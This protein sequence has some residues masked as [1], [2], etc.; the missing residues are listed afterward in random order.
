MPGESSGVELGEKANK[1]RK[2]GVAMEEMREMRKMAVGGGLK[3]GFYFSH[4][5]L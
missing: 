3:R 1:L 5:K 2:L 4:R